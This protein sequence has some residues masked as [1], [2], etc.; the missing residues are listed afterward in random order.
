[1]VTRRRIV[2]G[3]AA[4]GGAGVVAIGLGARLEAPAA[5]AR[6]LS[7]AELATVASIGEVLFPAGVFPIDG[8]HPEVVAEVDR[9][10]G[11]TLDALRARGFRYVLRTLEYATVGSRGSRFSRLD[12]DTR[13]AVLEAWAD[14]TVLV[15]RVSWDSLRVILG[16]A[17]FVQPEVQDAMEW[18]AL[19]GGGAP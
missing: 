5:G 9:V 18:R 16:M 2:L 6:A 7:A 11:D 3:G 12:V 14:P 1:M 4:L 17:F 13:R 15:R 10:V 19:C 8:G